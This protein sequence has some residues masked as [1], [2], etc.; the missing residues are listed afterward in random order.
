MKTTPTLALDNTVSLDINGSRQRV[1]LRAARA[2]LPPLLIVQVGPGFPV[3]H[4]VAKFQRRLHLEQDYLV[5]Y[6][7]QRGC[8]NASA[9][10]AER[11]SL[12]QQVDDLQAVLEWLAGETRQRGLLFGI[13]IGATISLLAAARAR[14]RLKAGGP[15][16]ARPPARRGAPSPC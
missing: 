1:R 2:G 12:A 3:L 13:S 7:E 11:S 14:G 5:A 4:E 9:D 10:D 6:W 15:Q 16:P 8:G